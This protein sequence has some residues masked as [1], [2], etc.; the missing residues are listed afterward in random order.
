MPAPPIRKVPTAAPINFMLTVLVIFL[1]LQHVMTSAQQSLASQPKI[2]CIGRDSNPHLQIA[3]L[4][5]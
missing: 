3:G 2:L 5:C 1:F 4:V